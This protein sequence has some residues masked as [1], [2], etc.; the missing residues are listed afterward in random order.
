MGLTDSGARPGFCVRDTQY[1]LLRFLG[2][3]MEGDNCAKCCSVV[4]RGASTQVNPS[5]VAPPPQRG[6]WELVRTWAPR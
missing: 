6:H 5:R 2:D 4:S 3:L 1:L